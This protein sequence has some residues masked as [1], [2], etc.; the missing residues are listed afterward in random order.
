MLNQPKLIIYS[1]IFNPCDYK[2]GNTATHIKIVVHAQNGEL[3][4]LYISNEVSVQLAADIIT[5]A[6]TKNKGDLNLIKQD[7]TA[8]NQELQVV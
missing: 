5:A 2:I 4:E 6:L 8:L 7:L 3:V 1:R